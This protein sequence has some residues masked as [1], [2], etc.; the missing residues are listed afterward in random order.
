M[1]VTAHAEMCVASGNCG[2]VAPHVFRNSED[3]DG[4]VEVLN[5]YPPPAEWPAVREAEFQCPSGTIQIEDHPLP[6]R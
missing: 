1:K 5:S 4:F 2:F 6:P 3:N